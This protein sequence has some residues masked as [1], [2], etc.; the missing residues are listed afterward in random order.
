MKR[1]LGKGLATLLA[2]ES[3][4]TK[5][6][7]G[8]LSEIAIK[9]I[10]NNQD[11]PRKSFNNNTLLELT[12]SIKQKG[13][14]QPIIVTKISNH[15]YQIIAGERRFLAAKLA[16]LAFIPAIVRKLEAKEAAEIA[17]IENVQRDDLNIMEEARAYQK[18]IDL[19][20]YSQQ[21]VAEKV[22]KSR[23]HITNILRLNNLE[24]EIQ[25]MLS[26]GKITMG[27]ARC[28]IGIANAIN[29]AK[30]VI[31]RQLNVRQTE[32]LVARL[33]NAKPKIKREVN[34]ATIEVINLLGKH[35][36]AD[37]EVRAKK[38]GGMISINYLSEEHLKEI[39]EKIYYD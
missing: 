15:K 21:E 34:E 17:I 16:G 23:S 11:Q 10:C 7:D 38:K 33:D 12:S 25:Q 4:V 5:T 6:G 24:S 35:L 27:H 28:L 18:L 39:V 8:N 13:V 26:S 36:Q 2:E 31:E 14:L 37:I 20:K 32:Q 1:G 3:D 30:Q 9:D 29:I 22:G 19:Y